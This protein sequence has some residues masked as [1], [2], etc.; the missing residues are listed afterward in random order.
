MIADD[1]SAVLLAG[2]KSSRM[3]RDKALIPYGDGLLWEHQITTLRATGI[4]DIAISV[5]AGRQ[6]PIPFPKH[7]PLLSDSH[8]GAGPI[9]GVYEA[10]RW[11]R[12]PLV[13]VLAVDLPYISVGFIN[14]L[15]QASTPEVGVVPKLGDNFEPV[16]AIY[17]KS[18]MSEVLA[19]IH[20]GYCK[21]QSLVQF[22]IE[23]GWLRSKAVS[24]AATTQF[25]NWNQPSD[26]N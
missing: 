2:G 26:I 22:G 8:S 25:V 19:Q 6:E 16:V 23:H 1:C 9:N 17:P 15:Y 21:L 10:L 4:K 5:A 14:E 3:G 12:R 13:L 18:R 11:S 24:A 20:T 7:F